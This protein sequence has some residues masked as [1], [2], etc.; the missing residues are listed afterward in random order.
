MNFEFQR[1]KI[2]IGLRISDLIQQ[3]NFLQKDKVGSKAH[4]YMNLTQL[5][6]GERQQACAVKHRPM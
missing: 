4:P 2:K 6:H 1:A 5:R 3:S